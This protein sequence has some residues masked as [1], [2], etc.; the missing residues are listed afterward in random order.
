MGMYDLS[1]YTNFGGMGLVG[2]PGLTGESMGA[3]NPTGAY[4]QS[5]APTMGAGTGTSSIPIGSF[6]GDTRG[7]YPAAPGKTGAGAAGAGAGFFGGKG[8]DLLQL[9][10]QGVGT[11]GALWQAWEANKLAK[12]Q[13]QS[14]KEFGNINLANQIQNYNTTLEDRSRSRA[15]TEGQSAAEAQAYIDKN[16]LAERQVA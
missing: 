8:M 5:A 4:L 11:I 13:F 6:M 10:L 1:Q 14:Q 15:F 12:A 9:G 16:R 7:I 3:S 2:T